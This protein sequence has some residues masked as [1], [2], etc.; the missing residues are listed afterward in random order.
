MIVYFS[1]SRTG[2]AKRAVVA[3]NVNTAV[4]F[5]PISG[6]VRI[7]MMC[8][9]PGQ[10]QRFAGG[11]DRCAQRHHVCAAP[12]GLCLMQ[13]GALCAGEVDLS[14]RLW[15]GGCIAHAA[16]RTATKPATMG[17]TT[18]QSRNSRPFSMCFWRPHAAMEKQKNKTSSFQR[19]NSEH[20]SK[21]YPEPAEGSSFFAHRPQ[22]E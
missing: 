9:R 10:Q 17:L 1:L 18:S 15:C 16:I 6:L 14:E 4:H 19:S 3:S 8:L 22:Y 20:G 12:V 2:T 21:I 5:S 7:T 13:L 11:N